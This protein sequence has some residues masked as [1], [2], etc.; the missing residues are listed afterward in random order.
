MP[1]EGRIE[2]RIPMTVAVYPVNLKEPRAAERVLTENV[3]P[4]GARVATKRPWQPGER[5][6][7][8]PLSGQFQLAAQVVYC[9]PIPNEGFCVGLDFRAHSF[10]WQDELVSTA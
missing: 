9:Q 8:S 10:N 7:I 4:H 1:L 5:Q 3:S 2:K 6:W